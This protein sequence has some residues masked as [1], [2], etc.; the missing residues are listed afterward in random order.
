MLTMRMPQKIKLHH[1]LQE[2]NTDSKQESSIF[3]KKILSVYVLNLRFVKIILNSG[4]PFLPFMVFSW[5]SQVSSSLD[6][7]LP[8]NHCML[9]FV[10]LS[11]RTHTHR[12]S[13]Q[14]VAIMATYGTVVP[15]IS[16]LPSTCF[17][18]QET[19]QMFLYIRPDEPEAIF[20]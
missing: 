8:L 9:Y 15:Y 3:L 2:I 14:M 10:C 16:H 6:V 18:K 13:S 5:E 19:V 7:F 4:F 1:R 12:A 20:H 17:T 11:R